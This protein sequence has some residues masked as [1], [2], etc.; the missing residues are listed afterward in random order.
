M[1]EFSEQEIVLPTGPFEGRRF[2]VGRNPFAGLWFDSIDSGKWRRHVATGPQ[3]SGKTL[4]AFVIPIIYH[5]FEVRETVICGVP[6]LDMVADKWNEDLLPAIAASRYRDLLPSAGAGSRGGNVTRVQFRNGV[7][8]RFMTGGGGDK[9][10]AGFTS[11]VL[12]ATEIDGMD[13]AGGASREADKLSQLEGRTRAYGNR[14]RVYLECTVSHDEGATWREYTGG[15]HS[16]IIVECA[17][18]LA[19]VTP[20]REHFVG[21]RDAETIVD[22]G[23][24]GAFCCPSCGEMWDGDSRVAAQATARVVHK[25]QEVTPDGTIT[26]T[27]AATDTLGFRWTAFNNLL[28]TD[29]AI[30][31][32]E[33]RA[34]RSHDEEMS[35]RKMRQFWW[36]TPIDAG[37]KAVTA[38]DVQ[39]ITART[40]DAG[41]GVVSPDAEHLTLG[42]DIGQRLA[43]WTLIEWRKGATPHIPDYGRLEIPSD[44]MAVEEAILLALRDFRDSVILKGWSQGNQA[45]VPASVLVDAG[46]WDEVVSRFC[47]E[48]GRSFLPAKGFGVTR[49]ADA[50]PGERK[51]NK[52]RVVAVGEGYHIAQV[53]GWRSLLVEAQADH[54]KT[55]L[56]A[57]LQTPVGR[58]GA[59]TLFK[60]GDHFTF[61]KHLTA[62]KKIEEFVP[63]KGAVTRWVAVSRNNHFL[64]STSL[65]CVAGHL[66]GVRLLGDSI[67]A[68]GVVSPAP[69]N[70]ISA[71]DFMNRGKKW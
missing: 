46:N 24:K 45:I 2:R 19:W 56:H 25:G 20:E 36:A 34:S 69:E 8:L 32:E 3:Q 65:G 67:P 10:R 27:P 18:C 21:W 60:G 4:T 53:A 50:R 51:Q 23:R 33:W 54:W 62:E 6:S 63:G 41:R 71:A 30:A 43:H 59:M 38:V 1:R 55:W 66:A 7:T 17:R 47:E 58:S 26:G 14:A 70:S 61:A 42:I 39:A 28:V 48:T 57:R 40:S 9:A 13:E 31:Q 64:D 68:A 22:A 15:T 52:T 12:A 44:M 5:L 37:G 35:E 11:R 29:A 16:R 49:Y